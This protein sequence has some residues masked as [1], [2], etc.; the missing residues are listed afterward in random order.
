MKV[1]TNISDGRLGINTCPIY[2]QMTITSMNSSSPLLHSGISTS[3][4]PSHQKARAQAQTW[5]KHHLLSCTKALL[6]GWT[7]PQLLCVSARPPVLMELCAAQQQ[8]FT[9]IA[10]CVH[11]ASHLDVSPLSS[12][13]PSTL[14]SVEL[15]YLPLTLSLS[16]SS[17]YL[18]KDYRKNFMAGRLLLYAASTTCR[19]HL[20][21]D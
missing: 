7:L 1:E 21:H 19:A 5:G 15:L 10:R 11:A 9:P 12:S 3:H 8:G 16:L 17:K 14:S 13:E 4:R 6:P 2:A 20:Y 18:P